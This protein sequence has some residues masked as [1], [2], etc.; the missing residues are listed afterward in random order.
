MSGPTPF[1]RDPEPQGNFGEG[2][3]RAAPDPRNQPFRVRVLLRGSL[4]MLFTQ[5]APCLDDAMR[6]AQNRWPDARIEPAESPAVIADE[7]SRLAQSQGFYD[8]P[9]CD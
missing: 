4:P 9:S 2:I 3:S 5:M 8:S 7:L 6:F 1:S